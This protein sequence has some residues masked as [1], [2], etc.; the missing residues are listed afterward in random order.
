MK[1][2]TIKIREVSHKAGGRLILKLIDW[3]LRKGEHWAVL[4]PNGAGKTTLL[5]IACGYIWPN[6]G[7][8]VLR[9]GE[10]LTDLRVLRKSIGW[11]TSTLAPKIPRHE[12][13]ID[14]VVSGKYAQ[15]GLTEFMSVQPT[16]DDRKRALECLDELDCPDLAQKKFGVL[17]QGEIQKVLISRARM[18]K[19]FLLIL[20]EPCAGMDPGARERFLQSIAK[21]ARKKNGPGLVFVTHHVEEILPA[22]KKTLALKDGKI[23]AV[24]ATK[25]VITTETLQTLYD[26]PARL[27]KKSDRYSLQTY[28]G[29]VPVARLRKGL[30]C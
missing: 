11:V 3:T 15:V 23:L 2:N 4:G 8:V 6:A 13:V 9:G 22:F 29:H 12:R 24:G 10:E 5:K 19:P 1:K 18:T 26:C 27:I 25:T 20:D 7:G 16:A 14:T 30:E 17:S 28:G 21:L